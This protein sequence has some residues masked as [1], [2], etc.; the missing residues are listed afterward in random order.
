MPRKTLIVIPTYDERENVGP[1]A[2]SVF[3]A[4]PAAEVL[5]VDDD[6]PDGTG[7]ELDRM[8]AAD[9]RVHVLHHGK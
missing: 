5:F 4:A 6:S 2:E 3:R 9:P 7:A 1:V 8:A